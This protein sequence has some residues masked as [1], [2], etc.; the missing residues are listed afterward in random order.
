MKTIL[1]T[2]GTP[3][4]GIGF[5]L[6]CLVDR[7]KQFRKRVWKGVI[8]LIIVPPLHPTIHVNTLY[9][10]NVRSSYCYIHLTRVLT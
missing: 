2:V 5:Q 4:D 8:I 7:K 1:D 10:C 3:W 6:V 9:R